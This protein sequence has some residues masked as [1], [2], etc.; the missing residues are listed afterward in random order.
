[1]GLLEI[2]AVK[3]GEVLVAKACE[4][5][6]GQKTVGDI[7]GGLTAMLG[8]RAI[9]RLGTRKAR[10]QL[11]DMADT[12]ARR[13]L[14]QY[15]HEFRGLSE[16]GRAV[17]VEAVSETFQLVPPTAGLVLGINF[18][19][20]G[21]ERVIRSLTEAHRA[22]R[23]F[24]ESETSMYDLLLQMCC[25]EVVQIVTALPGLTD[26]AIPEII[27]RLT[28]VADEVRDAPHRAIADAARQSDMAFT[29]NYRRAVSSELDVVDLASARLSVTSRR[30]P[31]SLAYLSMPTLVYHPS[32]PPTVMQVESA[33]ANR[34]RVLLRGHC[35]SG[36]TTCLSR[37]FVLAARR[38]LTGELAGLNG[39]VPFYLSLHRYVH[40]DLPSPDDFLEAVGRDIAG[41]MPRGW[42]HRQLR[43][44]ESLV[45]I[46]G[47]DEVPGDRR[48][49]VLEWV[50]GLIAKFDRPRYVLTSRPGAVDEDWAAV[51]G[52]DV[53][54]LLPMGPDDAR[55]FIRRW[56]DAVANTLSSDA[57]HAEVDACRERLL[58][59][60]A[61]CHALRALSANPL[62]CALMCALHRDNQVHLP[63]GW[64]DLVRMVVDVLV[65]ERDRERG[66]AD[67]LAPPVEQR[68]RVL[69]DLAY[70]MI[71]EDLAAPRVEEV[72][73]RIGHVLGPV[74]VSGSAPSAASSVLNHLVTRSGLVEVRPDGTTCFTIPFLRDYFA[75]REAAAGGNIRF[76]LRDS[77]RI[78]RQHLVVM[79][80]GHAPLPRAEELL[81]GLLGRA[82]EQAG[83][84]EQFL[85][86][87]HA[88][89]RAV[90]GLG[91]ELRRRVE[92]ATSGLLMPQTV[93][94]AKA[95]A[96]VG[97]LVVDL[98][99]EQSTDDIE[100]TLALIQAAMHIGGDDVLPFLA[101]LSTDGRPAVAQALRGASLRFDSQVYERMVIAGCPPAG[102]IVGSAFRQAEEGGSGE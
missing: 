25:T 27:G 72:Q 17:V 102:E 101:R 75:A 1:M 10:R 33:L 14:D 42:I 86:L 16:D 67:D 9:D 44:G 37:L 19:A 91:S 54:D 84:R 93:E 45:L 24:G 23:F 73:E 3:L 82:A 88:C 8:D 55:M 31:L 29:E 13:V 65:D 49:A 20:T 98:L 12:I 53:V 34:S 15:E 87:A 30:Y 7:A 78:E 81:S 80:A 28:A 6:T 85:V 94:D 43:D 32:A 57:A 74:G 69:Q 79:A 5:V 35:G 92:A 62:T 58:A 11:D 71:T 4:A 21:L 61:S 66:V 95:L 100:V 47:I 96:L 56:H 60:L 48:P 51:A 70:W 41:E 2:A 18:N 26:M 39:A 64:L 59:A 63:G 50:K 97:P 22:T 99:A 46:N 76:L 77:H 40:A 38:S 52:F 89:L 83:T 36:K 90:S 68:I